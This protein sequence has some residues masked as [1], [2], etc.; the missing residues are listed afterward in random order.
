MFRARLA[1]ATALALVLGLGAA[2]AQE[3]TIGYITKSATNAGWMM[4]NQGARDA[5]ADEGVAI[6]E[7]GPAF[8]DDLTSQLEVFENMV[9][10]DIDA[11]GIA[12]ADS[13]GMAPAIAEAMAAGIP[14]V[15]I[16]T[17][18]S[19]AEVTSFVATDNLAVAK[20]QGAVAA[21][22]IEDGDKIIYVT[23]SQAQSTGQDRRNG[24]LAGFSAARPNSEILEVPTEWNSEQA[25]EGVEAL[26]N[27][28]GDVAMVVHAWDGGTMASIAALT[29]LGYGPGDV[30]LVGF[31]GASD[32]IAAM[33]QG[34][35]HAN[36]AQML[37]E[38]G[39]QGIKAAAAAARGEP[40]SPRIDT[41]FFLVTPSTSGVYKKMVGIQ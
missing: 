27:Q 28:H 19:G 5:A 34:W 39:Y 36:T 9:A 16:D 22:L 31:D 4:I 2:Q 12:P 18:V 20:V 11:I 7:V 17:G 10:Q 26:I 41:G 25:Q 40:V 38:M 3:L 15:A 6:V 35:V 29:N 14:I 37:Y 23:G 33:D 8:A 21:T 13:A 1:A 30:K 24:F 32:A